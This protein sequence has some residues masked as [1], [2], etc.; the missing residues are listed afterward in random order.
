MGKFI[1]EFAYMGMALLLVSC[2]YNDNHNKRL[3]SS[4]SIQVI[5]IIKSQAT[6]PF[7]NSSEAIAYQKSTKE[8]FYFDSVFRAMSP[9][10]IDD[11]TTVLI[12]RGISH[13]NAMQIAIEFDRYYDVYTHSNIIKRHWKDTVTDTIINGQRIGVVKRVKQK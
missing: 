10:L 1:I 13:P 7:S 5:Q 9:E 3:S 4:D 12:N 8:R 6:P 2:G 11:V